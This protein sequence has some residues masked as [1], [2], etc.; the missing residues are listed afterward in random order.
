MR[1]RGRVPDSDD[2]LEADRLWLDAFR[3]GERAALARVFRTYAPLVAR[4]VRR[5][6]AVEVD[7]ARLRLGADLPEH[8]VEALVQ[9]VFLRA[10]APK[11]RESFD[12]VR[13]YAAWLTTIT[14]NVV[15]D[16]ARRV[17]R[18]AQSFVVV[19][20]LAGFA[21]TATDP[22]WG[23]EEAQAVRI[24]ESVKRELSGLDLD[25][26]RLRFEEHRT[27]KAAAAALG[28]SEIVVRRRDT[29][30]RALLLK[31]LRAEGFLQ[32]SKVAIGASLL[33]RNKRDGGGA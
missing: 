21:A 32:A 2:R 23:I 3:R 13:S 15:V 5:G 30:L 6:V 24:V 1:R 16:R 14:K 27:H 25:V 26:F 20:D 18:E 4:V 28:V 22:T 9:E 7:G 11:A 8:E 12:G 33:A 31:R 29:R 10:F 17:R 19:D